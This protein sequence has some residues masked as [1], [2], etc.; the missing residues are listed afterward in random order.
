[1]FA[2]G[3]LLA[4]LHLESLA[5][6]RLVAAIDRFV[7]AARLGQVLLLYPAT[8]EIVTVLVLGTVAQLFRPS[9]VG[10][11]K[12]LRNGQGPAAA[13]IV[14]GPGDR[15]S[16]S[17]G[18]RRRSDV[19]H[20]LSQGELAFRQ[21]DKLSGLKRRGRDHEGLRVRVAHIFGSTNDDPAG[22]EARVLA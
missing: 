8:L 20:R 12:M 10:V 14:A 1:L 5:D 11:A 21:P 4:P 3:P 19:R 6:L 15:Q 16:G 2:S 17:I 22:E 18:L 7:I 9:V 13:H